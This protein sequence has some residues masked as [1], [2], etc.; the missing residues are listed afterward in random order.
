MKPARFILNSDYTTIRITGRKELSIT[1]P[2][3]IEYSKPQMDGGYIIGQLSY[4]KPDINDGVSVYFTSSRYN[5]AMPGMMGYTRTEGSTFETIGDPTSSYTY[6]D[7]ID[8]TLEQKSGGLLV[9]SAVCP[10][11]GGG[12]G[13]SFRYRGYGQTIT[14][15]IITFKDPFSE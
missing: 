14:A 15:H 9:F 5:Y 4:N 10:S 13:F 8:Y 11:E 7:L 6:S 1:I 12:S 3:L 2:D